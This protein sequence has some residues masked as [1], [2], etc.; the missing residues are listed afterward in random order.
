MDL[1][2]PVNLDRLR[3]SP[4]VRL[5]WE[6][7]WTYL[8]VRWVM[9]DPDATRAVG[10][11]RDRLE[12]TPREVANPMTELFDPK[13]EFL[14]AWRLSRAVIKVLEHLPSDSRCLFRSLTLLCMLQRRGITQKLV[15]AVRA[16]PFGAHAWVEVGGDA[17]L[18]DAE[19]GYERLLEL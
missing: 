12:P 7:L 18:P 13:I 14:V 1:V 5:V 6:V 19:A 15:I 16:R 17:V 11:L 8:W 2:T 4:R 10:R 9:R 3:P